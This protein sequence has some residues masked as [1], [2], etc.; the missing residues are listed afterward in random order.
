MMK[1]L[2]CLSRID[3]LTAR[4]ELQFRGG[5]VRDAFCT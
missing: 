1:T 5:N 4:N 2:G 3:I